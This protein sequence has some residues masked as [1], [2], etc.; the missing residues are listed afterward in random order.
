MSIIPQ[1]DSEFFVLCRKSLN[2]LYDICR[3]I[4]PAE[5]TELSASNRVVLSTQILQK[6]LLHIHSINTLLSI[7]N[8]NVYEVDIALIVSAARNV[9]ECGNLYFHI[10]KR[11]LSPDQFQLR[12]NI[13]DLHYL[14]NEA[15][16]RQKFRFNDDCI[17]SRV[18]QFSIVEIQELICSSTEFQALGKNDREYIL[19]GKKPTYKMISPGILSRDVESA[20][21]NL[22]SNSIH[23]YPLGLGSSSVNHSLQFP[24]FFDWSVSACLAMIISR[25]YLANMIFDYLKLRRTKYKLITTM[26]LSTIKQS[27]EQA[28][29]S[30][31]I[32][33]L[34]D[35]YEQDIFSSYLPKSDNSI[36]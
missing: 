6:V 9:M 5:L 16:I 4:I 32:E 36:N 30:G 17:R 25:I 21:Y 24:S 14:K 8:R 18:H 2:E 7:G 29:L 27:K 34:R 33:R 12:E 15:D 1:V 19:S 31:L 10:T 26:Q 35:L 3:V 20:I 22:F 28:D 13:L 23:G 11:K